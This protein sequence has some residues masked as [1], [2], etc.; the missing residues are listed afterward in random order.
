MSFGGT[1][2]T[3]LFADAGTTGNALSRHS[4]AAI[5]LTKDNLN[6]T[7]AQAGDTVR[8]VDAVQNTGDSTAYDVVLQDALPAATPQP[9]SA[10]C[11]SR[12]AT[13]PC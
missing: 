9:T 8:I 5:D 12:A 6:L 4:P 7:G 1:A 11:R 10:I 13:A 2:P 3:S